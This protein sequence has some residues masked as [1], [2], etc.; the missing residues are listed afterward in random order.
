MPWL[1]GKDDEERLTALLANLAA[2]YP[3]SLDPVPPEIKMVF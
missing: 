3:K 2:P 1:S